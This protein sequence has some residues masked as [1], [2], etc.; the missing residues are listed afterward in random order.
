MV[1]HS[2]AASAART[3]SIDNGV[4]AF[5]L[6]KNEGQI[7]IAISGIKSGQLGEQAPRIFVYGPGNLLQRWPSC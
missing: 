3:V 1:D 6:S 4:R 5:N 7:V 2:D